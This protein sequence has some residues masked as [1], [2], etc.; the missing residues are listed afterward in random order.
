MLIQCTREKEGDNLQAASANNFLM[1][2]EKK[3]K[4]KQNKTNIEP[5]HPQQDNLRSFPALTKHRKLWKM[6]KW[7]LLIQVMK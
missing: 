1:L 7:T 3:N 5:L 2:I 4:T 6:N